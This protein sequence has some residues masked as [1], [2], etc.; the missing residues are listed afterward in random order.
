MCIH[1]SYE[2]IDLLAYSVVLRCRECAETIIALAEDL[3][4]D[5]DRDDV[6]YRLQAAE[7]REDDLPGEDADPYDFWLACAGEED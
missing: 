1:P 6:T 2:I 5:E 7:W 3:T 4:L